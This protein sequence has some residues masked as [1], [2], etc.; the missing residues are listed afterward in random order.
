MSLQFLNSHK[1]KPFRLNPNH[2]IISDLKLCMTPMSVSMN[3]ILRITYLNFF[4][5]SHYVNHE[6]VDALADLEILTCGNVGKKS[7][8]FLGV[9]P[10]TTAKGLAPIDLLT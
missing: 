6:Y 8:G 5:E 1:G 4:C 10:C 7:K 9:Y 2:D 3:F